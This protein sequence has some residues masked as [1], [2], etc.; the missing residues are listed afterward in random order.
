[1]ISQ[2]KKI[3]MVFGI[4]VIPCLFLGCNK[5]PNQMACKSDSDCKVDAAGNPQQ[6]VCHMGKCEECVENTDC[7]GLKQCISNRC[8]SVCELDAD[9]GLNR[10]CATGVCRDN[11]TDNE[12][13][14]SG[15][16]CSRGRCMTQL[17]MDQ[18]QQCGAQSRVNFDFNRYNIRDSDRKNVDDLAA[19]MEI[20]PGSTLLLEGHADARGTPSYNMAL[21]ERRALSVKNYL[22]AKGIDANRLST[23]SYGDTRPLVDEQ[24]E[25]AWQQ[26]RRAEFRQNAN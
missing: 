22:Q 18:S 20:N 4:L 11:C 17:M 14:G 26:N 9:C 12:T 21:G 1:M 3:L 19:C 25:Q 6:G 7:T 16:V 8:E 24:N 13:C 23:V 10:H 2:V 5:K 15:M